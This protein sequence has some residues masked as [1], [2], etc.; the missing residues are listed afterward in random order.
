MEHDKFWAILAAAPGRCNS[1]ARLTK[2]WGHS[3]SW[4]DHYARTAVLVGK[5]RTKPTV[6]TQP[7]ADSVKVSHRPTRGDFAVVV[8]VTYRGSELFSTVQ[9]LDAY[10]GDLVIK[11]S[12]HDV[13]PTAVAHVQ[14]CGSFVPVIDLI[15]LRKRDGKNFVL[16]SGIECSDGDDETRCRH[17]S[18]R[19]SPAYGVDFPGTLE[20]ELAVR[21]KEVAPAHSSTRPPTVPE[22]QSC[23]Q[24]QGHRHALQQIEVVGVQVRRSD[25]PGPPTLCWGATCAHGSASRSMDDLL[26]HV[27][28][29][30]KYFVRSE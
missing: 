5:R 15:L 9:E 16:A 29:D 2:Q 14:S 25:A 24:R 10:R 11:E 17:I 21:S 23:Q 20:V 12:R 7:H 6:Y 4:R 13:V 27:D 1:I 22:A 18:A 30:H 8:V 26:R 3:V 28:C 19:D